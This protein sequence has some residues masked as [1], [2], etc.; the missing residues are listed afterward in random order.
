MQLSAPISG[1]ESAS[2][3]PEAVSLRSLP[4][5][6]VLSA[7]VI[8]LAGCRAPAAYDPPPA[9][10]VPAV[11][12]DTTVARGPAMNPADAAMNRFVDSVLAGL[13]IEDKVGQLTQY[14]GEW[15]QTGPAVMAGGED[16]IR[17]GKVGSFLGIF[18]A[19]YT[20][21]MQ[22]IA[23]EESPRKIPLL[24][25]HDIIHG[26]RT[27]FPVPLA[28]AASWD[29]AAVRRAARVAAIE[30]TAFGLHWTFA[31]MVD[32]ARD[33]RWGRVVEGS[34]EDP[35][36]GSAMAVARVHGFQ[37]TDLSASNTLLATAKHFVAYGGAEG[38]RDYN[39][40]DIS[41]RLLREVYLPPFKAAIDA[42]AGSVMASFNDL[43]GVPLHAHEQLI[44]GVLREEWG[45]DGI[46]VSDYTGVMEL[47]PH[48]V[49]ED[50]GE[51]G[52]LALRA[53]V[54]VDM[55]SAIY[56]RKVPAL[57]RAGR[58]PESQ[59]DDAVRR[60]LRAKYELGLFDDPYR[61]SDTTRERTLA[62]APEHLAEA[63][64]MGRRSIV[65]L[66]NDRNT[67]PL[68]KSLRTIAVIGE[69]ATDARSAIGSWAAYGDASHAVTVLDGIRQA[70]PNARILHA[71]GAA[72]EGMDTSGFREAVRM[73]RQADAV[74]LVIGERQDM[75]AEAAN[76][77]SIEL[78]GVQERLARVIHAT[79]KP[80]VVV[81]MNGRPLAIPWLHE[82]VPAIVESW[83][84]GTQMGP[85]VADVL[86]GDYNPSGKLPVTFPRATG[87][88]PL[89]YN[90]RNTGRPPQEKEKYTSKYLDVPWTPLYPFGHGLSYTTFGYGD[91]QVSGARVRATDSVVVSVDVTNTGRVAG[92][93]IVQ[94]YLRDDVASIA[95]PVK[96]LRGFASV[97]LEPGASQRVQFVLGAGD[98]AFYNQAMDRVVEPGTFTVFVGGSSEG[99]KEARFE[100]TE[101]T[102][103]QRPKLAGEIP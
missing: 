64:D 22:R 47:I 31:P 13:T 75:S 48:G 8:S 83:Y 93:E 51:A 34:G 99:G 49:A 30:G 40:V 45:W 29:T 73:A 32:I 2:G 96:E 33:P 98:L 4:R 28:E 63:R 103:L 76:R 58:I 59:L 57:V 44:D 50:S 79:G 92:T 60:V 21:R 6:A 86:F 81:L 43:N 5:V 12:A 88:I 80:L 87:Q 10:S 77:A 78:P 35:H 74:I 14:R 23:V 52:V 62:L 27:I 95:R 100:V 94:L 71:K 37:G 72:V 90:H 70:V 24:F 19:A 7:F 16:E 84:L 85:A 69:L 54:D 3:C 68:S 46:L 41:E 9:P 15:S 36:L 18:G 38:G 89:Y 66:K 55:V 65:L 97:T 11:V 26:F 1:S 91:V 53:G 101:G 17:S 20:R 39:T 25:A 67:L 82:N 61:Y 102:R 56:L 42:G